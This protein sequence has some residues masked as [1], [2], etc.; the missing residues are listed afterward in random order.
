MSRPLD[1]EV[2]HLPLDH[3]RI[4]PVPTFQVDLITDLVEQHLIVIITVGE[5]GKTP[6]STRGTG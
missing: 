5:G 1:R 3:A 4:G 6:V 2:T